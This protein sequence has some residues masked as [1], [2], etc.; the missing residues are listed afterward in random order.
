MLHKYKIIVLTI[1][2]FSMICSPVMAYEAVPEAGIAING[3]MVDGIK[4]IK[5]S[6][7]YYVP[8]RD[9]SKL[10]GYNDIRFESNTKT[11]QITDGSTVVRLTM[12]GSRARRGDEYI[13]IDPPRW[14]N[15]M[16]YVSLDAASSLFNSFIYFKPE[17]GSIQVEKPATRYRV[18]SGD[19][20]WL[21]SEAHHTTVQRLMAANGL[22]STLIYP[23][24]IL[25]LPPRAQT[26]ELEPI[27]EKKPVEKV[28]SNDSQIRSE[29][30]NVAQ[31]FIG[32][33][34]KFGAT[35]DEAPRLFDCS[36]Y[37]QY[38][39]NQKGIQLPRTSR[40]QAGLGSSVPVASLK[41]GDLLFFQSPTL[42]SDGR[43]GH[44]GI[45]MDGGH[46][47]HASSSNGVHI[48]YNV[49]SNSYWGKNYLFAK[50]ILE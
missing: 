30:I 2:F 10:L 25:K 39:F 5:I 9:L 13:N 33:G 44:L 22:T 40:E 8:F 18:Q 48:T 4:P 34:Y 32:A 24:Q 3:K 42:Y 1:C 43:V 45:Y 17:N 12:G 36:S 27:K 29:I 21:I 41:Q 37:T 35:L 16:A 7:K 6:G 47:I 50:R 49:F 14:L 26:K 28:P 46:M 20:L 38:V 23:G 19:T 11:Y 31:R 15:E